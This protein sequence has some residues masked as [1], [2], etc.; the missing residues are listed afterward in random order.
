MRPDVK[1]PFRVFREDK[2]LRNA[3]CL[4]LITTL[5]YAIG[6]MLRL[7]EELSLFWPLN[8]VMAGIF[9]RVA[10]LNRLHNYAICYIAMLLYDGLTT[11]WGATSFVI[12]F[13]NMVFILT[14]ALL[15]QRDKHAPEKAEALAI[16]LRLFNYCLLAS[17]LCAFFGTFASYG[18]DSQA[19]WPLFADWF[20]EQFSTGVMIL[21]CILAV[22]WP[23]LRR[24]FKVQHLLPLVTLT[25]C[26]AASVVIGGAG[27]LAFPLP[28]L[29]WCAVRYSLL[30]TAV[31]TLI[32]G[33][34]EIVLV[35]NSVINISV[36]EHLHTSQMF[37]ARLGIATMTICPIMVSVSVNAINALI[38]QV[39]LRADFDFLTQVYSR[40]GLYELLRQQ[41]KDTH[42]PR[43]MS[44]M[45]LDIDYFKTINDNYG[46]EC[47]DRILTALAQ[48]VQQLV[49]KA[50][51][52][53]RMGGEEFAVI[54]TLAN[55]QQA[56][57]L[58]ETIRQSI[59]EHRF[60]W[61]QQTLSL[62]VSIGLSHAVTEFWQQT[63]TFNRLLNEA[64]AFLYLSKKAGRNRVS[65]PGDVHCLAV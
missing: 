56:L 33:A 1:T 46:H 62:T 7:V 36:A 22:S 38:Q 3:V 26:I 25:I 40:S 6:A 63:E 47:G 29:I 45:L 42:A 34:T 50:G 57:A 39:S 60:R 58:A 9:A 43:T 35:A 49:G 21:P 51:S 48:K 54:A 44:V 2:P 31:L 5:F 19:F 23:G 37:S 27:S 8:A 4:F 10:W 64:D 16:A 65:A 18:I 15:V 28:A 11:D 17:V 14:F 24:P 53:A 59:E 32:T 30:T 12:N 61:R 20:S 52:V 13:S 41:E 55:E